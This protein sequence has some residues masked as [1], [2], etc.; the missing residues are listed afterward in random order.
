MQ[1]RHESPPNVASALLMFDV[2][3]QTCK[4]YAPRSWGAYRVLGLEVSCMIIDN[5][6]ADPNIL[7]ILGLKYSYR[8]LMR[9]PGTGL[10]F[11]SLLLLLMHGG[12]NRNNLW[13]PTTRPPVHF[14]ILGLVGRI[15]RGMFAVAWL[16][17]TFIVLIQ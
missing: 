10:P 4:K 12:I 5:N 11:R 13:N 7:G 1:V 3:L 2:Q 15:V 14:F 9:W 8:I 17:C 16:D 6:N